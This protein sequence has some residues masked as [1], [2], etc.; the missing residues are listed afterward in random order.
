MSSSLPKVTFFRL[1]FALIPFVL[2]GGVIQQAKAEKISTEEW[3]ISADK[4]LRYE[5]PNSIVAE[6]NVILEKREQLP[7]IPPPPKTTLTAWSE[8]LE[9]EEQAVEVKADDV[10]EVSVPEYQTTIT[11]HADWMVYDVELE[12]IKAKGNLEITTADDKLYAKE[13]KIN[14]T[15]ETGTFG[16]ATILREENS[17]HLEGKTIEKTGFDT[18]KIVDGWVITCKVEKGETPP[19]SFSS[20]EVDIKQNG[21]AFL[22]HAKFNIKN[23]PV[24]YTPYMVVPVK[25]TRQT[26]FLFPEFSS[27]ANSGLGINLPF[28]W[29]ISDSA[30]ATFFPEYFQNRGFMPGLE[31]R[32]VSSASDKGAITGSYL[33][34]KLSD[35]SEVEYYSDTGFTHDNSDR[36]WLRGKAD[37]NFGNWQSRL[38]LDIVSDQDYLRE[39]DSGE[40]GFSKSQDR[41]LDVFGRGFQNQT[42]TLRKNTLKVLRSWGGM[43]LEA[44]LFAIDEAN[45]NASDINTP[46]MK[47]PAIDFTGALPIGDTSLSFDWNADYVDYWREDGIGGHRVDIRPSISSPIPLGAYLESRAELGLR[48]TFYLVQTYGTA[49][50]QNDDTQNRFLPE[51]ET[52]VATTFEK[53]FF[54]GGSVNRTFNHRMRPYFQYFY[55]PDVD[56]E[57][58]PVFDDVDFVAEKNLIVYGFDNFFDAFKTDSADEE[59]R[60]EYGYL[61]ID[62]SYDLRSLD[63]DEP[64]SDI[65]ARLGWKP[66]KN[67]SV[68]YKTLYDVYDNSFNSH[69]FE[70][71][72]RNSRGDYFGLDYSFKDVENI[73]QIN[74]ILRTHIF[75]N[76]I[77]GGDF[78]HSISNDETAKANVSLTYQALCWSLKFETRYTPADITYIVLFNLANIGFPLGFEY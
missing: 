48:D 42:D 53:D 29:N 30:D 8:L 31:F 39:F 17:L 63:T 75:N 73:D 9:E 62:Q 76:W 77:V 41:Y 58:L 14:L 5:N 64:F 67:A 16:D 15:S 4:V 10:A 7:L 70:G 54:K 2:L 6:G 45:T 21:Y 66:I 35:P 69:T 11:I 37:H 60:R 50:W 72:Y 19:W 32:Y 59:T 68:I 34:D 24:F 23:I 49:E 38:D 51:F 12:S 46:L 3:N 71:F 27:S 33:D 20:S 56:Q 55:N 57:D 1:L 74:A 78:E 13:G 65:Q 28:F 18:Y 36:Y 44:S 22:K 40:T 52:E 26:G 61:K 25:N 47:L 43:S